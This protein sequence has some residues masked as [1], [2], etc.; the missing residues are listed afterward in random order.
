MQKLDFTSKAACYEE[1]GLVQKLTADI[2]LDLA[3]INS[4]GNVL[5]LGCGPGGTTAKIAKMTS[6]QVVGIDISKGMIEKARTTYCGRPNLSFEVKDAS[7][8]GYV[9]QFAYIFCNSAFQWFTN[10]EPVIRECWKALKPGG[11][12]SIQAPATHRYCPLFV[13]AVAGF[14]SNQDTAATF[15]HFTS[16]Y[17]LLGS[18]MEYRELFSYWGFEVDYCEL[19]T[20]INRFSVDQIIGIFKSGAEN[21]Y[22][23]Q[24]YYDIA[25]DSN[26]IYTCREIFK[27]LVQSKAGLD[28]KVDLEFTRVY[29]KAYK[30]L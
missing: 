24:D 8:L 23:N 14:A 13:E 6:G 22:L 2:L 26:F 20:E 10:P 16:P 9:N 27:T 19:K 12:I 3:G 7:H 28:G 17:F 1:T 4:S 25:L 29:L 21:G 18:A 5:D 15:K 30:P 11:S